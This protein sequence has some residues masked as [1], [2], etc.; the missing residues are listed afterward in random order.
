MEKNSIFTFVAFALSFAV[1]AYAT[2]HFLSRSETERSVE[3]FAD[4]LSARAKDYNSDLDS[5]NIASAAKDIISE[6]VQQNNSKEKAAFL[7]A[8]YLGFKYRQTQGYKA[9]CAKH[10]VD[11]SSFSPYFLDVNSVVDAHV[12]SKTSSAFEG[13]AL[14][15]AVKKA[16]DKMI[17]DEFAGLKRLNGTEPEQLCSVLANDPE[18]I[19]DHVDFSRVVPEAYN[20]II[21]FEG[22][23]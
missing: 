15:P 6:K 3:E 7:F 9:Y 12:R 4:E 1:V 10:G 16:I 21:G 19:R 23:L 18:S 17:D 14:Q 11:T 13:E 22:Q 20:Y 8:S 5:E 2:Q